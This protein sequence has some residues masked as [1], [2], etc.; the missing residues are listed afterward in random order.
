MSL[1]CTALYTF[2]LLLGGRGMSENVPYNVVADMTELDMQALLDPEEGLGYLVS[3]YSDYAKTIA[4]ERAIIGVDGLKPVHRR[5]LYA[6]KKAGFNK[7]LRK[8]ARVIGEV[9]QYHPHG[10]GAIYDAL[11]RMTR[12]SRYQLIPLL[13]NKGNLGKVYSSAKPAH[14]RYTYSMLSP[15]SEI[16]FRGMQGVDY[17]YSDDAEEAEPDLLPVALPMGVVLASSGIAVGMA[18]NIP[19]NNVGEVIDATIDIATNGRTSH[20]LIPDFE[21][22]SSILM[23]DAE[24]EKYHKDGKA[25]FTLRANWIVD[26]TTITFTDLPYYTT[27]EVI[28]AQIDKAISENT[29]SGISRHTNATG[30][31]VEGYIVECSSKAVVQDVLTKLIRFT[32]FEINVRTNLTFIIENEPK[33]IGVEEYIQEW[34]KFR[35]RVVT[36]QLK[37]ELDGVKA[38]IPRFELLVDLLTHLEKREEFLN[39]LTRESKMHAKV[40]LRKLY[41]THSDDEYEWVLD[42][43]LTGLAGLAGKESQLRSLYARRAELE[44]YIENVTIYIVNE[45]RELRGKFASPRK[46]I[47]TDVRYNLEED[48]NA[49]VA[50]E[51]VPVVFTIKDKFFRK[52]V[53][54]RLTETLDGIHCMSDDVISLI[55]T[56]GRLIRIVLNNVNFSGINDRGTYVPHYIQEDDDFEIVTAEL[57][58]DKKIGYVYSD[59]YVSVVDY[60][61][62]VGIKNTKK[63]STR[64]V[65]EFADRIIYDFDFKKPYL[66]VLT[67]EGRFG[68]YPVDFRHRQRIARNKLVNLKP[69]ETIVAV[70]TVS[71]VDMM[72]LVT[73]PAKYAGRLSFLQDGDKFDNDYFAKLT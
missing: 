57:I 33:Q 13:S 32:D 59:G 65:S 46:T 55:D 47:L 70:R 60:G 44:G 16:M 73:N 66:Y 28:K 21:V 10:D 23:S 8:N 53:K 14:F 9:I 39:A 24:I 34:L 71:D 50:V 63:L 27:Y 37:R 7:E 45:L 69:N 5:I 31:N 51:A 6:M 25:R 38:S 62:W 22:G 68:L 30:L 1:E 19:S 17:T 36:R 26:G 43:K 58:E 4:V 54:D 40:V 35:K 48:K 52:L 29:I 3:C 15:E 67:N 2:I 42:K 56:K 18:S 49:K 20:R 11:C 72:R 41:P 61:E 12:S 64:G